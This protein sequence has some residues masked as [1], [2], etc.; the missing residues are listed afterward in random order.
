MMARAEVLR[1]C[2]GVGDYASILL[3]VLENILLR[4]E[5]EGHFC[6]FD[7]WYPLQITLDDLEEKI[8]LM[9]KAEG[10][11]KPLRHQITERLKGINANYEDEYGIFDLETFIKTLG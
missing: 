7:D 2:G 4:F 3:C 6:C 11:S 9:F 5:K 8:Q 10:V 1:D